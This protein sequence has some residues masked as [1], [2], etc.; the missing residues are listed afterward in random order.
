[1][2]TQ[3]PHTKPRVAACAL[4]VQVTDDKTRLMPAGTFHAPRGAAE[5]TG[6]WHL[7]AEAAQAII[8]LAAARSTDI[9]ID[10]EHQIL[11]SE[12][13]GKPAPASGWVDPRSLEWRE[14][15]LYGSIT[16]TAAASAAIDANEYRY[17]SPVFPYDAN[18]VPLDLLHLA[19]TNTPAIDEG[20]AQL[21][22][23]RMAITHDVNDDAQ[24]IDTVKREQLILTLGL[25]AEA[26]DEQI[27]GAIAVLKASAADAKALREALGAKDDAKPADAVA[28]LKASSAAAAPDMSQYVPV[29][30]YQETTQ[31][32]AALKA[33]SNTAELDALIKEGLEDGR[34]PGQ[35]TA[36]WLRVQGIAACK[37]HLEGAPSIAA[38][39][40]T[41]TQGK[42]PEGAETKGD[43][44]LTETELAVCK[45]AGLTPEQYR[46]ANPA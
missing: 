31:Q 11:Y 26:T 41:Q 38:L 43:G 13:N 4:R 35:A 40:T 12:K 3:S 8:Q 20:A 7:N 16:W 30:V 32:L 24:E 21:A 34:I 28:A 33:N 46:A 18:G 37:A 10:Y 44:S 5:G 36:D 29:A 23:A 27:D 2:T 15:G 1:M 39:K 22:A 17:L 45:A 19:L 42:P 14:D 25:A 9:A 6:P